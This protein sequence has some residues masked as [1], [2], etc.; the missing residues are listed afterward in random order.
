MTTETLEEQFHEE[1][2]GVYKNTGRET[3]YWARRYLQKVRRVGGL[4]VAHDL[5]KPTKDLA[6]GLQTLVEKNRIDLS[7]EALVLRNPWSSF[8]SSEEL[9]VA[10]ERINLIASLHLPEEVSKKEILLEGSVCQITVNH[11]E[12]NSKARKKCIEYYGTNCY[13]C[14]FNFGKVYGEKAEGFIHVHHLKPLSNICGEYEVN[15]IEDLRPVCPNCHA[16]IHLGGKIR[17]I[18]D[19]KKMITR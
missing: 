16:M 6:K 11:Y 14:N 12:R 2:I 17:S 3:G 1:M 13:V 15:P 4:Q 9:K 7:V 8:F 5:L 10:Q 19:V 18:K